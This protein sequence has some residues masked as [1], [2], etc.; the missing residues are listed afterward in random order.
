MSSRIPH[1]IKEAMKG[2]ASSQ[3]MNIWRRSPLLRGVTYTL[4][5]LGALALAVAGV[6]KLQ[7]R[8]AEQ[9]VVQR[10]K[11]IAK[12][13]ATIKKTS[14]NIREIVTQH[15]EKGEVR[16]AYKA[17]KKQTETVQDRDLLGLLD[18]L[19]QGKAIKA[20]Y[21]A[22][23]TKVIGHILKGNYGAAKKVLN[24]EVG[25]IKGEPVAGQKRLVDDM[26]DLMG[27]YGL[28][29]SRHKDLSDSIY[30]LIKKKR[31]ARKIRTEIAKKDSTIEADKA[32]T[33]RRQSTLDYRVGANTNI[34]CNYEAPSKFTGAL[35]EI[36]T[37]Q[38]PDMVQRTSRDKGLYNI[39]VEL[40]NVLINEFTQS[41]IDGLLKDGKLSSIKLEWQDDGKYHLMMLDQKGKLQKDVTIGSNYNKNIENVLQKAEKYCKGE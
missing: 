1:S 9:K 14:D 35:F 5:G 3:R 21:D 15:L 2:R 25:L 16:E 40:D 26:D 4:G 17:V 27:D 31:A 39:L 6:F 29:V 10:D 18:T 8:G 20:K 11:E 13:E 30:T 19:K 28:K 36:Y 22:R 7:H 34:N 33:A 37:S 41:H 24:E 12:Q 32:E 23:N 38:S